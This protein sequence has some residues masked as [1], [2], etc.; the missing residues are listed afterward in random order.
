MNTTETVVVVLGTVL[1]TLMFIAGYL[2]DELERN[3]R[4]GGTTANIRP[5]GN[6]AQFKLFGASCRNMRH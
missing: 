4:R 6:R 3:S 5:K 1:F 2:L